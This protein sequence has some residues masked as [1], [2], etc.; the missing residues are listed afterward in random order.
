MI[1][2]LGWPKCGTSSLFNW[3]NAHP[4][5]QGSIPKETF[6]LMDR[7]HPFYARHGRAFDQVGESG[8]EP[9]FDGPS[10][11]R[12]RL[13]ATTHHVFQDMARAA[14]SRLHPPPRVVFVL[15][16]PADRIYSSYRWRLNNISAINPLLTF[17]EYVNALLSN[18]IKF[19]EPHFRSEIS[20]WI[21]QRELVLGDYYYWIRKWRNVLPA[22]RQH[23]I[24]F[25]ELRENNQ[26]KLGDLLSCLDVHSG[27]GRNDI[28]PKANQTNKIRFHSIQRA[29]LRVNPLLPKGNVKK[30]LKQKYL[31]LQGRS[32]PAECN[33]EVGLRALRRHFCPTIISLKDH[34]DLDLRRW[35]DY[36]ES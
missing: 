5:I 33:Y 18:N 28:L 21:A 32:A 19:L 7:G 16:D 30:W 4:A 6:F 27:E 8:F 20:L 3:L 26:E 11:G 9:F 14:I 29:A 17:N 35:Q 2:I 34:Y 1:F 15:R 12:T 31:T 36:D 25:E 13:E 24:L 10:M 22:D 23:V